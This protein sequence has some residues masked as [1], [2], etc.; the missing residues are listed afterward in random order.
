M[1]AASLVPL[2]SSRLDM[3][4]KIPWL[5]RW[6]FQSQIQRTEDGNLEETEEIKGSDGQ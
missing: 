1:L 6:K 3:L 5:G 2:G 4:H